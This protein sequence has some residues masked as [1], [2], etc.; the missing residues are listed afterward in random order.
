MSSLNDVRSIDYNG[1]DSNTETLT[2]DIV[3]GNNFALG[4]TFKP[5]SATASYILNHN[6]RFAIIYNYVAGKVELFANGVNIIGTD[7]RS[8]SAMSVALNEPNKIR[9]EYDGATFKGFVNDVEHF[10]EAVVFSYTTDGSPQKVFVGSSN[11][12]NDVTDSIIQN[13]YIEQPTGTLIHNWINGQVTGFTITDD[14]GSLNMLGTSIFWTDIVT[15]GEIKTT[16]ASITFGGVQYP[17]GI[18]YPIKSEYELAMLPLSDSQ[19]LISWRDKGVAYDHCISKDLSFSIDNILSE[20]R[21]DFQEWLVGSQ[22]ETTAPILTVDSGVY[23]LSPLYDFTSGVNIGMRKVELNDSSDPL[24]RWDSYK[25]DI[26][27]VDL[28]TVPINASITGC[29]DNV[30][31]DIMGVDMPEPTIKTPLLSIHDNRQLMSNV[32]NYNKPLLHIAERCKLSFVVSRDKARELLSAIKTTRSNTFTFNCPA[33]YLPF[34]VQYSDV[35][36]FTCALASNKV[37]FNQT[38]IEEIGVEFEI[39]KRV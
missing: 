34:G 3:L 17:I 5:R 39:Q 27:S 29:A 32:D 22:W 16:N 25:A 12:M 33:P 20:Q 1:I 28:S 18:P 36:S 30:V 10:S 9:Y 2:T 11:I 26:E 38:D 23:P 24:H 6:N 21:K 4:A 35:T 14:V 15:G 31:C 13:V 7:P 19:G 37:F 8:L